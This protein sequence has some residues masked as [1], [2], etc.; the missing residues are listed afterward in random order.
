MLS[1]HATRQRLNSLRPMAKPA[2]LAKKKKK[3]LK[4]ESEYEKTFLNKRHKSKLII[5]NKLSKIYCREKLITPIDSTR[6]ITKE[7]CITFF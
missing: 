4:I 5:I 1:Y 7:T 2:R 6:K 3:Q